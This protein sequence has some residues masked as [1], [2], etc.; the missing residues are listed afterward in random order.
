MQQI[1][2]VNAYIERLIKEIE[3]LT[4]NRLLIETRLTLTERANVEL[5]QKIEDL[6]LQIEKQNKKKSREVNTSTE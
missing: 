5:S 3:E 2:F 6:E 4:K 1:E